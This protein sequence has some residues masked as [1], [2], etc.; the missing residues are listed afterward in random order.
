MPL[1][2]HN[3]CRPFPPPG[4][5]PSRPAHHLAPQPLPVHAPEEARPGIK[6]APAGG[7]PGVE[8]ESAQ[9][10]ELDRAARQRRLDG[11]ELPAQQPLHRRRTEQ[12]PVVQRHDELQ[13]SVHREAVHQVRHRHRLVH[14]AA[15]V[16]DREARVVELD[17]VDVDPRV[18]DLAVA[19]DVPVA[20]VE[21]IGRPVADAEA[22]DQREVFREPAR[23]AAVDEERAHA[24]GRGDGGLGLEEGADAVDLRTQGG[25]LGRRIR[26]THPVPSAA[27]TPPGP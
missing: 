2:R 27:S 7:L 13:P 5:V 21:P 11:A 6:V 26:L 24:D 23:R 10:D 9:G 18:A 12:P 19:H 22:P 1:P 20:A 17:L 25:R 16:G 15:G 8:I 14:W 3:R 4:L